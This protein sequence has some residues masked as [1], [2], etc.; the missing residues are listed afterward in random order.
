[1]KYMATENFLGKDITIKKIDGSHIRGF[2]VNQTSLGIML[3]P[4][5]DF[6]YDNK[7]VWIPISQIS[8]IFFGVD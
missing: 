3:N 1:M 8:E 2:C 7:F 5:N 4:K 6:G